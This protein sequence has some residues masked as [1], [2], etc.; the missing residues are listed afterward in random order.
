[1]VPGTGH[2]AR[3]S[4]AGLGAL[5][6]GRWLPS[7]AALLILTGGALAVYHRP[8]GRG[9]WA[10]THPG[11]LGLH[12]AAEHALAWGHRAAGLAMA[13]VILRWAFV[14]WRRKAGNGA[15]TLGW[16][17]LLG[18]VLVSGFLAPW[19]RYLPWSD[20][21]TVNDLAPTRLSESEGP[22]PELVG[23]RGRYPLEA[24]D[25]AWPVESRSRRGPVFAWLHVLVGPLGALAALFVRQ[26]HRSRHP[27]HPDHDGDRAK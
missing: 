6:G 7:L 14:A 27:R 2:E 21:V 4:R 11:R 22:F 20:A 25:P 26:V 23:V 17:A 18:A 24:N 15:A 10:G 1:M 5:P 9:F 16:V 8:G 3:E 13:A 12:V 19:E